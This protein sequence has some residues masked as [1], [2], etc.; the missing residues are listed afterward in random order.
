MLRGRNVH[1]QYSRTGER[2]HARREAHSVCAR[3]D[4][5][6]FAVVCD[7]RSSQRVERLKHLRLRLL[8]SGW[9]A[10]AALHQP[11][12]DQRRA[13]VKLLLGH[14]ACYELCDELL[15]IHVLDKVVTRA[16]HVRALHPH[17]DGR[18][19]LRR[20]QRDGPH[21]SRAQPSRAQTAPL[22]RALRGCAHGTARPREL[23]GVR[24]AQVAAQRQRE[25]G[26]AAR[27]ATLAAAAARPPAR[28]R[29]RQSRRRV[30]RTRRS[31]AEHGR[32]QARGQ[33]AWRCSQHKQAAPVLH[34]LWRPR[35]SGA[36]C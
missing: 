14:P 6:Q 32:R 19:S 21:D 36:R 31:A 9:L 27:R 1:A 12:R 30:R 11:Q 33:R 26:T 18:A 16:S 3:N 5:H 20:L 28:A 8:F 22:P 2:A 34:T 29:R 23:R 15:W 25:R 13:Y 4:R 24:D 17:R 35:V 7:A 10:R